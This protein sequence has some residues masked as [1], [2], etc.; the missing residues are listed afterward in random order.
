MKRFAN[1]VAVV[2]G[3]ANGIGQA[4][5][6]RL[7]A[8]GARVAVLDLETPQITSDEA[9]NLLAVAGD[10]TDLDCLR[11]FFDHVLA[12]LGEIEI[13]FNNVGQSGRDRSRLFVESSEDVWR[14]VVEINLMTTMRCCRIVAPRMQERGRGR[15]INMSSDAALSGDVRLSDYAAIKMGIIGFTRALANEL[16]ASRVTVNAVC[17]GAV[18]T[19]AHEK[20][21]AET[22]KTLIDQTPAGFVAE[23]EDVAGLVAYLASDEARF[24]TGQTI[25]INGGRNFL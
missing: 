22:L 2:T 19:R 5:A 25:A 11:S 3:G 14:F 23:P 15:I 12:E 13:L 20:I 7:L 17:P 24:I 8:E 1:K 6:R 10:C 9:G 4:T 16:A 18:R 21:P